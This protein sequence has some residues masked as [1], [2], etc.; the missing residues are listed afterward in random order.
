MKERAQIEEMYAARLQQLLK[1]TSMI[2][3]FGYVLFNNKFR[4]PNVNLIQV[5]PEKHG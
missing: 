1:N 5:L 3:E 4:V 2:S